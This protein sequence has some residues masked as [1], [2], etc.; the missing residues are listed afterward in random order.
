MPPAFPLHR[1]ILTDGVLSF[2]PAG[3][4]ASTTVTRLTDKELFVEEKTRSKQG[5][6]TVYK[7]EENRYLRE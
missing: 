2:T 4:A 3:P 5:L 7:A 6:Y 1:Y